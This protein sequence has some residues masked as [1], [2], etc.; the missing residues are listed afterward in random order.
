LV[1]VEFGY[2]FFLGGGVSEET[3]WRGFLLPRLQKHFNPLLASLLVWFPWALWHLP[4]D[5][6][7]YAGPTSVDYLRTRVLVLV[8]LS[9]IMT[10]LYNRCGRTILSAALFHSSFNVAPDF[11]PSARWAEGV[12]VLMAVVV[13]VIDKMWR[14]TVS[15]IVV[16]SERTA[17]P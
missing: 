1:I 12:I 5:F 4:L 6:T 16:S 17:L 10:W 15:K 3:G 8:P 13:I 2:A 14:K 11:V 7:G 9:I